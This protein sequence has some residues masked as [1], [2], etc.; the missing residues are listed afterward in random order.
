[1]HRSWELQFRCRQRWGFRFL[2]THRTRRPR[3]TRRHFLGDPFR[4]RQFS[5]GSMC[6]HSAAPQLAD[7]STVNRRPEPVKKASPVWEPIAGL[8]L[9]TFPADSRR[10][11]WPPAGRPAMRFFDFGSGER[12]TLRS[13]DWISN[14][15][16]L[17]SA[18]RAI[19]VRPPG[20]SS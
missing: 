3:A 19:P 12:C 2:C 4:T 6:S 1:M 14:V 15:R 9:P 11:T 7:T 20:S 17:R 16:I 10:G 13:R 5:G 18:I 8:F